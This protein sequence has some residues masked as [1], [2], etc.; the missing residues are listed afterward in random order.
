[1]R[2][3]VP[4]PIR[5]PFVW[6][7]AVLVAVVGAS[8][9][10]SP[11]ASAA[12]TASVSVDAGQRL[13]TI[14]ATGV[15]TNV[16]VYDGNMNHSAVPGL[17]NA[18]GIKTVRYP[19]GSYAD[20][21]HWQ[22]NTTEG[23]YVAAN[24]DFDTYMG[25]VKAAGAQPIVIANYGSGTPQEAADWVRY[26][27]VTK[28]YG[29]KYWEIGNEIYG[30]G[31]YGAG[32]ETDHHS[33]H[34]ATTYATNLLQY[35]S[36]MKAV[37]PTVKIGAVLTTP[38]NWPDGITGPGDT[39]D[40]NHTV[41]S[42]AGSKIDFVIVHHYPTSTSEADLLAKPHAEI[43]GMA[44]TLHSLISQYAGAHAADVG[45]AVTE[46]NGNTYRDT[47]PNG[48]FAPDEYL[49]WM[50][51]GAFN[52]DWW[53]LHNGTDCSKVTTV[54]GA[55]DY[56]DYGVLS[57]GASCEPALNTPFAPY[58]GTQMITKLGAPGD[59]L[60]Q[61]TGS[62]SLLTAHA[63][64][65][66]NGDVDVM[67]INK[68][69]SN[70]ATV[71]LS[72]SGFTPS[73]AAPTVYT[74]GKNATS[75]TSATT[76][77]PNSQTVPAYSIVVL[78]LHPGGGTTTGGTTTGGSTT[79]GTTSG[80]T[81]GGT[82]TGGTTSGTATGG[83][84]TGGTGTGNCTVTYTKSEWQG[85]LTADVSVTNTGSTPVNGWTLAFGFPGDTKVT[86]AWNATVTQSGSAVSAKNLSYNGT[87][88]AGASVSFGFQGTWS[89]NDAGP[90][91]FTLN[92]AACTS[93]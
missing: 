13:A 81:T 29:V 16:A 41:L 20:I 70:A 4:T 6:A 45:I 42:I 38:G 86:S 35:A 87:I 64:K 14:P 55:T 68:D 79:G 54:D 75:I 12:V 48:L 24:T 74:Y 37:D 76:G 49:T 43:P 60:V 69:P 7:T 1:M 57:S 73:S 89:G 50:E 39:Q 90:T 93:G 72:Y 53:A 2:R 9:A 23:G 80:T 11:S 21:Y 78:Q 85:G 61:A 30:N 47:A 26:A 25:T 34:S 56:D 62:S 83:T 33:S 58:Y 36:A 5:R 91:G 51:N 77:S 63:V 46:A 65:R 40:W 59:T 3:F 84:T 19:G 27:N 32:W 88:A 31:E 17:L 52:V 82:T 71:S 66:A 8:T 92:G 18:A 44:S 28:G 67:L 15:G 22:T 10:A